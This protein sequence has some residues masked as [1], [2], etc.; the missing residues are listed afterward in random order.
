M[1][2]FEV[3][4]DG[5]FSVLTGKNRD[6]Y[7]EL[8]L[9]VREEYKRTMHLERSSL[10]SLI[11]NR[12]SDLTDLPDLSE[13]TTEREDQA[14]RGQDSF[15]TA[16]RLGMYP[17][18]VLEEDGAKESDEAGKGTLSGMAH[19]ILRRFLSSGWVEQE[20]KPG[21][22][23]FLITIPD[24]S[25]RMMDLL[26]EITQEETGTYN[27]YAFGAYASLRT[28]FDETP[29]EYWYTALITARENSR[30]LM[31]ALKLLL[32]N[33]R[34]YHRKLS[35]FGTANM[36][37]KGHFDEYQQ[38]VNER[39]FHPLVTR[40]AV[41]RFRQPIFQMIAEIQSDQEKTDILCKQGMLEEHFATEEEASENVRTLLVEIYDIFDSVGNLM[42]DIQTK[43][44]AYTKASVDKLIYLLYK[45]RTKKEQIAHI[46]MRFSDLTR[47]QKEELSGGFLLTDA[48]YLDEQSLYM[49]GKKK[50]RSA[51][52][53]LRLASAAK[54]ES[55]LKQFLSEYQSRFTY[56]RTMDY[57]RRNFGTAGVVYSTDFP[58]N[59]DED[60]IFLLMSVIYGGEKRSFY[61]IEFLSEPLQ[62]GAYQYPKIR[63][64]RKKEIK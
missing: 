12:L 20:Q 49:K 43:N 38:L 23:D 62:H 33:I 58:V 48:K 14:I 18:E 16:T 5:F 55:D 8:L 10:I 1:K 13:D 30:Q 37:L 41:Q 32:N 50:V 2:V 22:F 9:A 34:R 44:N 25:V 26:F 46:L 64:S 60:F 4:P 31:D 21:S 36:I 3:L 54:S 52:T 47:V 11:A 59:T 45:D 56:T 15:S 6:L 27:N 19:M 39:I 63:Y 24:Y 7:V 35:D 42:N 51:E 53:P 29:G 61:R 40:D 28:L 17:L 57:M